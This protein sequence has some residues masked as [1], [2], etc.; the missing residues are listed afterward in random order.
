MSEP[1]PSLPLLLLSALFYPVLHFSPGYPNPTKGEAAASLESTACSLTLGFL[2]QTL[3]ELKSVLSTEV[4]FQG[5]S[6]IQL[7]SGMCKE[8]KGREEELFSQ[9]FEMQT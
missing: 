4:D 9:L 8:S 7:Q 1:V 2:L 5:V 3:E 6:P